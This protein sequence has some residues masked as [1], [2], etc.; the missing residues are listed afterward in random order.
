LTPNEVIERALP[1]KG[2]Y[3]V[4]VTPDRQIPYHDER[5]HRAVC[6]WVRDQ[7]LDE[8]IDL[9]DFMDFDQISRFS[10]GQLRKISGRRLWD[11]YQVGKRILD[12]CT[13]AL[14]KGNPRARFT[15]L[16]GN[17]DARIE[18]WLDEN[19]QAEG[20]LELENGLGLKKRKIELVRCYTRGEVYRIGK[21]LFHHGLYTTQSHAKAHADK[22][23]CNI[24]YG[25]VHDVQ[26]FSREIWSASG[27]IVAQSLG[28]LCRFDLEYVRGRPR[29][30]QQAFALVDFQP[31]GSF[32]YVV[33]RLLDGAFYCP[34]SRKMYRG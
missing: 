19:P 33:L 14:R 30:W 29:N 28:C 10:K 9:G 25:H 2:T 20:S 23:G 21:A 3:R 26:C 4:L 24:F 27:P 8:W 6:K 12:D 18:K 22:F 15:L 16:E 34:F 32:Q 13:G 5:A 7:R 11:D 31:D 17:H 1:K